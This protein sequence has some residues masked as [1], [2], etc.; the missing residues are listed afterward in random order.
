MAQKNPNFSGN[1]YWN[2]VKF[3]ILLEKGWPYGTWGGLKLS[4]SILWGKPMHTQCTTNVQV[5]RYRSLPFWMHGHVV[6]LNM[7]L[8]SSTEHK[9][10]PGIAPVLHVSFP[11]GWNWNYHGLEIFILYFLHMFSFGT[12]SRHVLSC[13]FLRGRPRLQVCYICNRI[14]WFSGRS[15]FDIT[16]RSV[17]HDA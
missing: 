8:I 7:D 17:R 10:E 15:P 5:R 16:S 13:D 1:R 2:F 11:V 3:D 14:S 9:D 4:K 12:M 6:L